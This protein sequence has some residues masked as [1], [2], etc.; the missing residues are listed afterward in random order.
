[1]T[2]WTQPSAENNLGPY[3]N[4]ISSLLLSEMNHL[5]LKVKARNPRTGRQGLYLFLGCPQ[6]QGLGNP[7]GQ[8][9]EQVC[10]PRKPSP[11]YKAPLSSLLTNKGSSGTALGSSPGHSWFSGTFSWEPGHS[12]GLR[13]RDTSWLI[14]ETGANVL[15]E[16]ILP[17]CNPH[18]NLKEMQL[19]SPFHG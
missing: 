6:P 2:C 4:R 16:L 13:V 18:I 10:L 1:M 8:P 17:S 19:L 7:T 11:E 12:H 9:C 14:T 3:R 5:W 15:G